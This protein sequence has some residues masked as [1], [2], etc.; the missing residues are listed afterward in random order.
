MLPQ[1]DGFEVVIIKD[2]VRCQ[3]NDNFTE[4]YFTD[5]SKKLICRTLKFYE[6]LLAE[7]DFLRIHKSHLI[8][9]HYVKRYKKG[10]GGQVFMTDNSVLDVAPSKKNLLV[11]KFR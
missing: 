3:A 8:N 11:E 2:I 1:L 4:F 7:L 5:G 6:E 9:L 10:K